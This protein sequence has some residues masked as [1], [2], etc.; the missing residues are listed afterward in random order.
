MSCTNC[1]Q[2]KPIPTCVLELVIGTIAGANKNIVVMVE[3]ITQNRLSAIKMMS[4]GSGSIKMDTSKMIFMENHSYKFEVV[5]PADGSTIPVTIDGTAHD[6]LS[7]RFV[8]LLDGDGDLE[9]TTTH[10]I[11]MA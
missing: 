3:D 11:S 5:E 10:T 4:D 6:C 2:I 8:R 1:D 7:A 9:T